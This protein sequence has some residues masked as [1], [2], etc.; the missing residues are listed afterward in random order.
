MEIL[1]K[2]IRS[3]N[4]E[5]LTAVT[6]MR[7]NIFIVTESFFRRKTSQSNLKKIH[8]A[9]IV[10]SLMEDREII[11]LYSN[12]LETFENPIVFD[13][14]LANNILENMLKLYPIFK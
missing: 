6:K 13:N 11:S 2:L 1:K 3:Q 8:I 9:K 4:R 5:G 7:Q 14:D 12:I 10:T